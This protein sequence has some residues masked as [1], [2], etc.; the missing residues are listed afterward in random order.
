MSTLQ[1]QFFDRGG[2]RGGDAS[3]TG[4][5]PQNKLDPFERLI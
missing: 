4:A 1:F 5:N 2:A 3:W